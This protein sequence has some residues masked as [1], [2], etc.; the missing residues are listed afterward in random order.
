M[1]GWERWGLR[2]TLP[3]G[4]PRKA[5]R[6]VECASKNKIDISVSSLRWPTRERTSL[7][8]SSL[9]RH[10]PGK[11]RHECSQKT[12]CSWN[13]THWAGNSDFTVGLKAIVA[14]TSV[15]PRWTARLAIGAKSAPP[16]A[17]VGPLKTKNPWDWMATCIASETENNGLWTVH[18]TLHRC[19]WLKPTDSVNAFEVWF[20]SC[21]KF[22]FCQKNT[23]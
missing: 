17:E 4:L 20:D 22:C 21:L 16:C 5:T 18:S 8:E 6:Y 9:Q 3:E 15:R 19:V 7:H 23:N 13:C 12:C 1:F 10:E 11:N 14:L 2:S